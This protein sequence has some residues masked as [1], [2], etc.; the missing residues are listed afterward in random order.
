MVKPLRIEYLDA[1]YH[2]MNRGRSHEEVF[3]GPDDYRRFLDL[4]EKSAEMW[5]VR[6]GAYCMMP[7]AK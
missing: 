4:L 1:W 3:P 2:V 7:G 6:I 5:N